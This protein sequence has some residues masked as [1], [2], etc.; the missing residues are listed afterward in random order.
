MSEGRMLP[1]RVLDLWV[2]GLARRLLK[3]FNWS[4]R[5]CSRC[6]RAACVQSLRTNSL[7][8]ARPGQSSHG[9]RVRITRCLKT[10]HAQPVL[11]VEQARSGCCQMRRS[12]H[13]MVIEEHRHLLHLAA[14]L[15]GAVRHIAECLLYRLLD[16]REICT[17][18]W[19]RDQEGTPEDK[20]PHSKARHNR[21][22][23]ITKT[24]DGQ[25]CG[26]THGPA[27]EQH[28]ICSA[29][30]KAEHP[31]GRVNELPSAQPTEFWPNVRGEISHSGAHHVQ[32]LLQWTTPLQWPKRMG[33]QRHQTLQL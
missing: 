3:I 31:V 30:A 9:R 11:T 33:Q 23:V 19:L 10:R 8:C 13:M 17:C 1:L 2:K 7:R 27:L 16:R 15:G 26:A 4:N 22:V 28:F 21:K 5:S 18:S 20:H 29:A 25:L 12:S 6:F 32:S 24:P 14:C